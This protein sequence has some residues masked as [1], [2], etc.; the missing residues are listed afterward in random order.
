MVLAELKS[1]QTADDEGALTSESFA[2]LMAHYQGLDAGMRLAVAVSGGPDSMALCHLVHDWAKTNNLTVVGLTVDHQLRPEA[3]AEAQKVKGWLSEI[4][5][6]HET[7]IWAEGQKFKH[8]DRSPQ[9]AARAG[10]FATLFKWC[11]ENGALALLTAHHADDQAETFLYRLTRGSGVDGLASIASE[12]ERNGIRVLR[13][14]L[15]VSKASLI[16][17]CEY[18]KQ[19]WVTDPSNTD[20]TFARVRIRN[21]LSELKGE[22]LTTD[23]LLKTVDHM[24]RA[25]VAI[26]VSVEALIDHAVNKMEIDFVDLDVDLLLEAPQEV[27][28]RCLSR[29]LVR[30]AGSDYPPRFDSLE[31]VYE[32]LETNQWSDRTLNGCQIR[33]KGARLLITQEN[34]TY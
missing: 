15:S 21:L 14:L 17:T 9:A 28:L 10:R 4:G 31:S 11:R 34:R 12:I 22:G 8:L 32:S 7:L 24:Q 23:R 1:S 25:K 29:L 26:D 18:L 3:A 27:G 19:D 5:M 33:R 20:T 16:A 13:P 2:G 30:V 6:A